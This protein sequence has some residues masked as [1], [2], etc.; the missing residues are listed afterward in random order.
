MEVA[1]HYSAAQLNINNATFPDQ[2]YF[3]T[4]IKMLDLSDL[5]TTAIDSESVII[6]AVETASKNSVQIV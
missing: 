3:C 6:Q 2:S 1:D 4:F 5:R